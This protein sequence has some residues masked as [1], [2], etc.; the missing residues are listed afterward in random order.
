MTRNI[1]A[2]TLRD[3]RTHLRFDPEDTDHDEQITRLI[4]AATSECENYLGRYL[5]TGTRYKR[6]DLFPNEIRL[7]SP[8][9]SVT[10][11][12]Y[13]DAANVQQTLD[14][15][16]YVV[17]A[18]NEEKP[19]QRVTLAS[20]FSWPLTY[21]RPEAI[22]IRYIC[23]WADADAVPD[24]IRMG[25]LLAVQSLFLGSEDYMKIAKNCWQSDRWLTV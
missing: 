24:S 1:L 4:W 5:I 16:S 19:F 21:D 9:S 8:L 23:G 13:F 22:E 20:G 15:N 10:S 7:P 17:D 18:R 6:L 14:S 11:I 3:C 2:V 12:N 25:L